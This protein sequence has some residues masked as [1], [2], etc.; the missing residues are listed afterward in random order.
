MIR[1]AAAKIN[2]K[3][4]SCKLLGEKLSFLVSS[5]ETKR[6]ITAKDIRTSA[7]ISLRND[8]FVL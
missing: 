2:K 8:G 1:F 5:P 7:G 3:E 4:Q 6:F